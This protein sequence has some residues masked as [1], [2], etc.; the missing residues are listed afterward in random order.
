MQFIVVCLCTLIGSGVCHIV[1]WQY[2]PWA[3]ITFLL[4]G[5]LSMLLF[6]IIGKD[7]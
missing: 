4:A 1:G 7:L 5:G 6:L 2:D 3:A